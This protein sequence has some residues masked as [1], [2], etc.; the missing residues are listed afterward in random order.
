MST[1]L[2]YNISNWLQLSECKSNNSVDLYITVRQIIDDGSH[3]LSGTSILVQHNQFG[4]LFA[5]LVNSNGTLLTP[6]PD[7]GIIHE[8]TT[9][10][11]LK[12]LEKF[13]FLV[14]FEINQHLSG[15]QIS[16]LITL[17]GL[18]F[19]KLRRLDVF[20][21]DRNGSKIVSEYIV[22]FN[23]E[24]CDGWLDNNYMCPKKEFLDKL[25][26]G[27][28]INLTHMSI[29]KSFDWTWLTYVADI[30]D[31]IEDNGQGDA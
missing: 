28:A 6:D 18:N 2:R 27:V 29:T 14:T 3:R 24:Q 26:D 8:F 19:D 15:E 9:E 4:V 25:N 7:S 22:A 16:Y 12:E 11:I 30:E 13:G 1:P 21:Y 10:E 20:E 5:C 17:D 31:I 23:V